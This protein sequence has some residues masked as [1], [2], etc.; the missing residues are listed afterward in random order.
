MWAARIG[1]PVHYDPFTAPGR[2]YVSNN[3]SSRQ[4]TPPLN[5]Q[6]GS[7]REGVLT[8]VYY[9]TTACAVEFYWHCSD[10]TV[11][12]ISDETVNF[13]GFRCATTSPM[14]VFNNFVFLHLCRNT[15]A[16]LI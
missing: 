8:L 14:T 5:S 2:V 16:T 1:R 15:V 10:E 12:Y 11:H 4:I 13:C 9:F 7:G 6:A 3:Q